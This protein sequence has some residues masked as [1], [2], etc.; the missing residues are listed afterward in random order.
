MKIG[1]MGRVFLVPTRTAFVPE[2]FSVPGSAWDRKERAALPLPERP[3]AG[4]ACPRTRALPGYEGNGIK[5]AWSLAGRGPSTSLC[6]AQGERGGGENTGKFP[7]VL[8]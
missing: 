2:A 6:Y 1:D 7:F 3:P 8:S 4:R 5:L